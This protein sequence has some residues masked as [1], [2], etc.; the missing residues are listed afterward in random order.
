MKCDDGRGSGT[1]APKASAPCG[2]P[3]CCRAKRARRSSASRSVPCGCCASFAWATSA[4]CATT[5]PAGR[6]TGWAC[7]IPL[8]ARTA[9]T[10]CGRGGSPPSKPGSGGK[11][12]GWPATASDWKERPLSR[13]WCP[14]KARPAGA[15]RPDRIGSATPPLPPTRF[16]C[17]GAPRPAQSITAPAGPA[18]PGWPG[19][20]P[21]PGKPANPTSRK[22]TDAPVSDDAG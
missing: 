1:S 20:G 11:V 14:A 9:S 8:A 3:A 17:P 10:P 22:P 16:P 13:P 5:G 6:S 7:T 12:T 2:M 21:P 15:K 18:R 4:R 19:C